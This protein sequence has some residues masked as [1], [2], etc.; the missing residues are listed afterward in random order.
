MQLINK[1]ALVTG[2]ANGLGLGIAERFA[3]EGAVVILVDRD[4]KGGKIAADKLQN[5]GAKAHFIQADLAE[6]E[7]ITQAVKSALDLCGKLD[8]VVNNAAVFLP[9]TIE[10]ITIADW[11]LLMAVNLRAPF[12][13]AQAALPALKAAR[14]NILNISSTAALRV[15]SPNL[16]YV[17]AKA[18]LVTM[19]KSLAQELQPFRIRV[20]CLCPGAVDTPALRRDIEDRAVTEAALDRLRE[21]GYLTTPEQI[22]AVALH[23]VSAESSAITGSIVVAD[24]G[25][26]LA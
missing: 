20:N 8:I 21:Q 24:A 26:M 1:V 9:K 25:A 10:H 16:P 3:A 18:G 12:L 7:A 13:L 14:G 6:P 4:D 19:T 22:A 11:D 2:A 23:L 15:F 17:T 5:Q